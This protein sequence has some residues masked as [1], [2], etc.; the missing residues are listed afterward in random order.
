VADRATSS[1]SLAKPLVRADTELRAFAAAWAGAAVI[2]LAVALALGVDGFSTLEVDGTVIVLGLTVVCALA[3]VFLGRRTGPALAYGQLFETAPVP[4]RTARGE[5]NGRTVRRALTVAFATALGAVPIALF[6][7]GLVLLL[8][9]KPRS[10]LFDHLPAA[11]A[12]IAAGW[13][14]VCAVASRVVAAWFER[15][16]HP[17]GKVIL[18]HPMRSGI[19]AHVY[20]VVADPRADPSG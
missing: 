4:P 8:F 3:G 6:A 10:E 17:R 18:C 20:Y 1:G 12:L 14:L 13:M 19:V 9:G 5:S 11:A 16:E 2:I 7:L 15:W